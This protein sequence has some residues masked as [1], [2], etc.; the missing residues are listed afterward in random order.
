MPAVSHANGIDSVLSPDGEG[1]RC[2]SPMTTV[3]GQNTQSRVFADGLLVCAEGD[4]VAPHPIGGCGPDEQTLSIV[5]IRVFVEGKGIGRIGDLYG[6]NVIT[7]G[8]ARVF[9]N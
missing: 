6:D 5:S 9:S 4:P 1:F 8:S 2:R 3:T 7:S